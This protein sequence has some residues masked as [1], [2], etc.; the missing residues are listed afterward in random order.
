[1]AVLDPVW[2]SSSEKELPSPSFSA[3]PPSLEEKVI[4][5]ARFRKHVLFY[6][7]RCDMWV[8]RA[9]CVR[10]TDRRFHI[11]GKA[12][13]VGSYATQQRKTLQFFCPSSFFPRLSSA[14][15]ERLLMARFSLIEYRVALYSAAPCL[16]PGCCHDDVFEGKVRCVRHSLYFFEGGWTNFWEKERKKEREREANKD[17]VSNK[18]NQPSPRHFSFFVV[19]N[20]WVYFLPFLSLD[21][22]GERK[23]VKKS[24][25]PLPV[26]HNQLTR[27]FT[28]SASFYGL[29]L[30]NR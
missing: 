26:M 12:K 23:A 21:C 28:L 25:R 2:R 10:T 6:S 20:D 14:E 11:I 22:E 9:G 27:S 29:N 15:G 19:K 30:K 3:F 8:C 4:R 7:A 24:L 13:Q 16:F 5:A 17:T 18:K 1:M